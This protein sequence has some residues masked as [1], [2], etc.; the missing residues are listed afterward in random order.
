MIVIGHDDAYPGPESGI[1]PGIVRRVRN[2]AFFLAGILPGVALI[3]L[4][5]GGTIP[6][7]SA[8]IASSFGPAHLENNV[9]MTATVFIIAGFAGP[10][11]GGCL[12]S[13]SGSYQ[14]AILAAAIMAAP[15]IF[16]I[17]NVPSS[18]PK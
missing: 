15:G 13:L 11:A 17:L 7:F 18:C 4:S 8:Y 12:H 5:F 3:A 14:A 16:A 9:G 1:R 10:F 2:R 6:Q